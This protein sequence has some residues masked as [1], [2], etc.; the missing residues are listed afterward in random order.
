MTSN[1]IPFKTIENIP[2]EKWKLLETKKIYFGHQSVGKNIVDGIKII[3]T[4]KPVIDL[5]I[6]ESDKRPI[7]NN[8]GWFANSFIGENK[9]PYSKIKA[10]S[11]IVEGQFGNVADIVFFKFC[12]VDIMSESNIEAIF[13]KY[14]ET[15]E[16]L[17]RLY[18]ATRFIHVTI[19]LRKVQDG[20][21]AYIKQII[22]RP[23][24]EYAENIK[25]N[26]YNKFLR[27]CY[28]T[29]LFDL[30]RFESTK[31]DGTRQTFTLN[32]KSYYSMAP[33]YTSDKGHLNEIGRRYVAE[34]LLIYLATLEE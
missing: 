26:E 13:S 22:G 9:D 28:K 14:K 19:P 8:E 7:A 30:A 10:F 4:E 3:L 15:M 32:D 18:G 20:P 25:R 2:A 16:E 34:Q 31:Q 33:E 1:D 21:K 23:I 17:Q 24:D 29:N 11:S 27:D 12:Y 6:F 5:N